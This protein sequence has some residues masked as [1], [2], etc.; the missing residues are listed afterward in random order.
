M[1]KSANETGNDVIELKTITQ[2]TPQERRRM[3]QDE[4][5]S[6]TATSRQPAPEE[7]DTPQKALEAFVLAAGLTFTD[8]QAFGEES[9]NIPDAGSIG[10]RLTRCRPMLHGACSSP[11]RGLLNALKKT[12]QP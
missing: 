4:P 11:R 2:D 5:Q 7:G 3:P 9:G 6:E 1:L 10:S 8:L 12:K